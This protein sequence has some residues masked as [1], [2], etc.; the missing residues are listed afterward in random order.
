MQNPPKFLHLAILSVCINVL[1]MLVKLIVG[2]LG[3]SYALVADGIESAS[4]ILSSIITWAGFHASLKPP[5]GNHPFGHG[6]FESLAGLFSG[7]CLFATAVFIVHH[8]IQEILVPHHAPAW[9]TLPVL[10]GVV[11][12]KE[13]LSRRVL[14]AGNNLE[15]TA[16]QGDAWHHRSDAIS[17]GAAAIGI[18]VALIGGA[19]YEMADDWAALIACVVIFINGFRIMRSSLHDLLDGSVDIAYQETYR[20]LAE[21]VEG[22]VDVE[23]CRIRRSGISLF[24]DLHVRVDPKMS[25]QQGHQISHHV[26]DKLKAAENRIQEVIVHIEPASQSPTVR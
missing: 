12:L 8:S 14:V 17:S 20:I 22:V 7:I 16:L 5:D 11:V 1:L 3:N 25:V 26:V 2:F 18:A 23:K 9:F 10:I 19:G 6:K 4:D 15:S 24:L 13:W 21:T